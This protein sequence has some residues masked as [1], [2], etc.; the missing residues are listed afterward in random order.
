MNFSYQRKCFKTQ[1]T[2]LWHCFQWWC[3]LNFTTEIQTPNQLLAPPLIKMQEEITILCKRFLK[4]LRRK[5]IRIKISTEK[6]Y[7]I[8]RNNLHNL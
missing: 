1:R 3:T 5:K 2:L 4:N 7:K 8:P 6:Y